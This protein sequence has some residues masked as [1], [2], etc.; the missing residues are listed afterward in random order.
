[1]GPQVVGL[2]L[3][4]MTQALVVVSSVEQW[5]SNFWL[6]RPSGDLIQ[7][8]GYSYILYRKKRHQCND[9]TWIAGL[10]HFLIL[11]NIGN[12]KAINITFIV[13]GTTFNQL[14]LIKIPSQPNTGKTKMNTRTGCC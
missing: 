14:R 2:E 9:D 7:A 8:Q 3:F 1:M 11:L 6:Y 4:Q 12:K 10:Q 5:C 13:F